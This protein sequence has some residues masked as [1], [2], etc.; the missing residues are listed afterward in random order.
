[1]VS[2]AMMVGGALVNALAFTVSNFLFGQLTK[3]R[4][5]VE[6]KQHDLA[7]EKLAQAKQEFEQQCVKYLD[8]LNQR[9]QQQKLSQRTFSNVD[10]ALQVYN[11]V[12]RMNHELL[13]S[14]RREP[15]LS[16]FYTPSDD[17]RTQEL[18]SILGGTAV[19]GYLTYKFV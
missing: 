4:I 12:T 17:Q 10:K 8:Y 1:M 2:I 5:D 6:R 9:L 7:L 14:L 15:Q 13:S 18:A 11:K 19:V 16:N 3:D